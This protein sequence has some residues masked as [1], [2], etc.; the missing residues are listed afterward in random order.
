MFFFFKGE[1]ATGYGVGLLLTMFGHA[2]SCA[3]LQSLVP[4]NETD[5]TKDEQSSSNKKMKLS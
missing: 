4:Y 5:K 1:R 3:L 2:S